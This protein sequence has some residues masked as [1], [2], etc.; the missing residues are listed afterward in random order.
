MSATT[1][2]PYLYLRA[3]APPL[4][5]CTPPKSASQL[6]CYLL[7][8]NETAMAAGPLFLGPNPRSLNL[9]PYFTADILQETVFCYRSYFVHSKMTHLLCPLGANSKS[10]AEVI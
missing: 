3:F 7:A 4:T 2:W 9:S 6:K 10:C 1:P 5:G 8:A